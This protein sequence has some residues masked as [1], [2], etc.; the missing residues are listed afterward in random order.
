MIYLYST[1]QQ[2]SSQE[3]SNEPQEET[4]PSNSTQ[5]D[6]VRHIYCI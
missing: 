2:Q 1:Q 6:S 4:I 3:L 5:Q